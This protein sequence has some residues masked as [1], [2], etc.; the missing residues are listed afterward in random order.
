M[1]GGC[2]KEKSRTRK[3][4][5]FSRYNSLKKI[6]KNSHQ[7]CSV[8]QNPLRGQILKHRTGYICNATDSSVIKAERQTGTCVKRRDAH[9]RGTEEGVLLYELKVCGRGSA[10]QTGSRD[11]EPV[12]C[13]PSNQLHAETVNSWEEFKSCNTFSKCMQASY[14]GALCFLGQAACLRLRIGVLMSVFWRHEAV[15][16]PP[17]NQWFPLTGRQGG[18]LTAK[19]SGLHRYE[20]TRL[21][22]L[23]IR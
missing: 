5:D 9:T 17:E 20:C 7:G 15:E 1:E 6:K 11:S 3:K 12:C 22:R 13:F 8:S 16:R 19:P 4:S 10:W 14:K 2:V 23:H 21:L 18:R